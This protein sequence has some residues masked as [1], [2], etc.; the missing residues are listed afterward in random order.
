M[1][2]KYL[3]LVNQNGEGGSISVINPNNIS[4]NQQTDNPN[5]NLIRAEDWK[6]DL[7]H[8]EDQMKF[9]QRK[10]RLFMN[11]DIWNYKNHEIVFRDFSRSSNQDYNDEMLS[12][13]MML[14]G[15]I[16][17][18]KFL[19]DVSTNRRR[20]QAFLKNR[21]NRLRALKLDDTHSVMKEKPKVE[22]LLPG[23]YILENQ[24][25]PS[26]FL[27][28]LACLINSD[29]QFQTN[30]LRRLIYPHL[31]Q[32]PSFSPPDVYLVKL[33]VNGIRRCVP[34]NGKF[35]P[36]LFLTKKREIFPLLLEKGLQKIYRH[37]NLHEVLPNHLLY[38]LVGWI[39]E[40]LHFADIG[41]C[42][43][44]FEKLKESFVSFSVMLS[45]DYRGQVLPILEF[46]EDQS[47]DIRKIRTMMPEE[48]DKQEHLNLENFGNDQGSL[49]MNSVFKPSIYETGLVSL[50]Q[51]GS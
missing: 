50:K 37:Q 19:T 27:A 7:H 15:K 9:L 17:P 49:Q 22:D 6:Q 32:V 8:E 48:A 39:P 41:N 43:Q 12:S 33:F 45:F 13:L 28:A 25:M 11:L 5:K 26:N 18:F 23:G 1:K 2:L 31:D 3:K 36:G 4:I 16:S 34:M 10:Q 51:N 38:R 14:R 35:D 40:V 46:I 21:Q 44:S 20:L 24:M 30:S 47:Q 42:Q 29:I